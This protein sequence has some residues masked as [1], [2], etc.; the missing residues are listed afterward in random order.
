MPALHP[1][2][3][4][5]AD[6][7]RITLLTEGT[8]P[9]HHGGVSVWCDQLVHGMPDFTFRITAVTG[10]GRE[11]LAWELPPNTEPPVTVPLW[12]PPGSA[13]PPRGGRLRRIVATYERFL[14]ALVDPAAAGTFGPTLY[15]LAEAAQQGEL[16]PALRTDRAL[17]ALVAVWNR[18]DLPVRAARPTL[19]DALTATDLLE[20]ALR[21]LAA[22][23]P[24]EGV[25]HAVSGGLAAL[26]GLLAHHLHGVPLLLTEHG[27][28][29]R[30]RYLGYRSGPYTWP[31]KYLMLSFFR[32]LAEETYRVAALITPG[33]RYNRLWEERGGAAARAIRT[34]YNGV[35]P[36]AFP[37]AGPEPERPTLSWAGRVDPIKDL[38]TLIRAFARV[39]GEL[40]DARLRLFGGTPRGAEEYRTRCEELAASLGQADAV[41]FEGRVEDIKDAYAAG[42]VVM[43]SSISEGFPFTLIEAMS[44]GRATVSTDVGGVRE[45]VGDSG[46]VVP[47]R[48]PEAM[49]RAALELLRDAPR[50][51]A[52]GEA[53]RLR[54]IEQFTLRQTIDTFRAVYLELTGSGYVAVAPAWGL[55]TRDLRFAD[56]RAAD[57]RVGELRG[58]DVRADD[59]RAGDAWDRSAVHP[60]DRDEAEETPA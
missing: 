45:A 28:Y 55:H 13:R 43:L 20:H 24:R 41:T 5:G 17:R 36:A 9:H 54:V 19:H 48:D 53:A 59:V 6:A 23:P 12:G 57:L 7:P 33:N 26:P 44:C 60:W 40:P 1:L 38:E 2:R 16:G 51:A 14:T 25:A 4:P 31:V 39:R 21:P 8:Y 47:P 32:L 49:A 11:T 3:P 35:D 15:E 37:P 29:L 46:L 18:E 56:L 30:E 52:M 34:V 42:N 50:R 27:V 10:T 22:E 58:G